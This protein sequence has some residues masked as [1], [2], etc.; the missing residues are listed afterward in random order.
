MPKRRVVQYDLRT[1][2]GLRSFLRNLVISPFAIVINLVA[3]VPGALA[4]L[5]DGRLDGRVPATALIALGGLIPSITSGMN[6][7]GETGAFYLGE[8]LGVVFLFAG[9]VVSAQVISDIRVPFTGIVI[10]RR[11]TLT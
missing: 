10:L 7:F 2:A 8:F 3:S 4:A 9:F 1:D 11:T 5:F 6:R